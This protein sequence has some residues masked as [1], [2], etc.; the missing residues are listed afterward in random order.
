M[1]MTVSP[2]EAAMDA[3]ESPT[4]KTTSRTLPMVSRSASDPLG[5]CDR[6]HAYTVSNESFVVDSDVV[7]PFA[8]AVMTFVEPGYVGIVAPEPDV[9][10]EGAAEVCADAI[11]EAA[12]GDAAAGAME[13]ALEA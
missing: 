12:I 13:A 10:G 9:A 2:F 8:V 6:Y 1:L 7:C 11:G 4:L 5:R 3:V